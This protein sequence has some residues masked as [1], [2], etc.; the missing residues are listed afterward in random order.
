MNKKFLIYML[1]WQTG[2]FFTWPT[3][4]LL[5]DV[6]HYG[7]L[8]TIIIFQFVGGIIYWFI[9]KWIFNT[10]PIVTKKVNKIP[11]IKPVF[12]S[13]KKHYNWEVVG[14]KIKSQQQPKPKPQFKRT[15]HK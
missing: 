3:I 7:N 5:K 4:Y 1:R 14:F 11:I 8:I 15:Q 10:E 6:L 12:D 9:D 13:V 2:I